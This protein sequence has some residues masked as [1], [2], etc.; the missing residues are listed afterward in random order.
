MLGGRKEVLLY[1]QLTRSSR[2]IHETDRTFPHSGPWAGK[3]EHTL[4]NEV[5]ITVAEVNGEKQGVLS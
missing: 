3:V 4:D 5:V 1:L 2:C